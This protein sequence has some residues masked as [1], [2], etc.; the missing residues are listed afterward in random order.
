MAFLFCLFFVGKMDIR[1]SHVIVVDHLSLLLM[2]R[3][4]L[5]LA[6]VELRHRH[7]LVPVIKIQVMLL[8]LML[9]PV[10]FQPADTAATQLVFHCV[11]RLLSAL[12][13]SG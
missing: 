8:R 7:R 13:R 3:R 10:L 5:D 6:G 12:L 4:V 11:E 2:L 1:D 9:L